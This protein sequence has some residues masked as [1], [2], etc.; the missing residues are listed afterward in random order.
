VFVLVPGEAVESVAWMEV[1]DPV[2]V[3]AVAVQRYSVG[4]V[5]AKAVSAAV[6]HTA[7]TLQASPTAG[8]TVARKNKPHNLLKLNKLRI[9]P[10][11]TLTSNAIVVVL[12]TFRGGMLCPVTC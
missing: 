9:I 12:K 2:A 4:A 8:T 1:I 5:E 7:H 10:H 6:A 3:T 11:L